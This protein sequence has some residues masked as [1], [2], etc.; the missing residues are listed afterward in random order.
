MLVL[1]YSWFH[2]FIKLLTVFSIVACCSSGVH[3]RAEGCGRMQHGA[4]GRVRLHHGAKMALQAARWGRGRRQTP[5]RLPH[6]AE[7]CIKLHSEAEVAAG[8]SKQR[9]QR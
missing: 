3:L 6:G 2:S 9:S 5:C 1:H 4:E 7:G 8:C